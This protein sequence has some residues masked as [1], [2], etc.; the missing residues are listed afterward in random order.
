MVHTLLC[1]IFSNSW[2]TIS[3]LTKIYTCL[4][5][6]NVNIWLLYG[7]HNIGTIWTYYCYNLYGKI[8]N[9]FCPEMTI[10][11]RTPMS[12]PTVSVYS[13]INTIKQYNYTTSYLFFVVFSNPRSSSE[14]RLLDLRVSV[15]RAQLVK[16]FK[17]V[18]SIPFIINIY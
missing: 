11:R 2:T 3:L 5:L 7:E 10:W 4:G 12:K 8:D 9:I 17:N 1:K 16:K 15:H 18:E 6:S 13:E 14:W